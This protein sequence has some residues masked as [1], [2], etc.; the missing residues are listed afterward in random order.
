MVEYL[1]NPW[2][3]ERIFCVG[4]NF[5]IRENRVNYSFSSYYRQQKIKSSCKGFLVEFWLTDNLQLFCK[6]C[7]VHD[8]KQMLIQRIFN[9]KSDSNK[10]FASMSMPKF[11]KNRTRKWQNPFRSNFLCCDFTLTWKVYLQTHLLCLFTQKHLFLKFKLKQ[12][13]YEKKVLCFVSVLMSMK[14]STW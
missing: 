10:N 3:S 11:G 8:C 9:G 7:N 2:Y 1:G 14:T 4:I 5:L 12:L 13:F 6:F